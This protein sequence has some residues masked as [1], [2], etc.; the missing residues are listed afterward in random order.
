VRYKVKVVIRGCLCPTTGAVRCLHD[1]R[2]VEVL[3]SDHDQGESDA[4]FIRVADLNVPEAGLAEPDWLGGTKLRLEPVE[5]EAQRP[6]FSGKSVVVRP[7]PQVSGD[8]V[9]GHVDHA[10]AGPRVGEG[11]TRAKVLPCPI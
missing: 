10:S 3:L 6:H 1:L 11:G 7:K 5:P 4:V 8:G 9:G 2:A